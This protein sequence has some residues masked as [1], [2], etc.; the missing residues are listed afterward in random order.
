VFADPHTAGPLSKA[1]NNR[2][3]RK[4]LRAALLDDTHRIHDLPPDVWHSR[5]PS[6]ARGVPPRP[7]FSACARLIAGAETQQPSPPTGT[8]QLVQ[9]DCLI[10]LAGPIAE[11]LDHDAKEPPL[12]VTPQRVPD[13]DP[14][15][16]ED[17]GPVV[18]PLPVAWQ[19]AACPPEWP[20]R[21][22]ADADQ[23]HRLTAGIASSEEERAALEHTLTLR[24]WAMV[25]G[26][27]FRALH[28]RLTEALLDRGEL[29]AADVRLELRRAELSF[30]TRSIPEA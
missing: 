18:P 15:S 9:R 24:A 1:P 25:N 22:Q 11:R 4:A 3:F 16:I 10:V 30:L 28:K 13:D 20:N 21:P 17:L 12:P 5:R 23:V 8:S 14:D 26:A 6:V 7:R 29:Y 2:R 27:H 19:H